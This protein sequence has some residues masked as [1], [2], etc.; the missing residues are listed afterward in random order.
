MS[1]NS[2]ASDIPNVRR[3]NV[4]SSLYE[5][6]NM[7]VWGRDELAR[8]VKEESKYKWQYL[9]SSRAGVLAQQQVLFSTHAA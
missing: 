6:I 5:R 4:E 1:F 7:G 9:C 3:L 8:R 2:S